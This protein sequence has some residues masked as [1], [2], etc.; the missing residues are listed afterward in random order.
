MKYLTDVEVAEQFGKSK[1]F[2]Q[3]MC[4][5][6][7]WPHMQVGKAYRF[8]AEHV[9]AIEAL[10]EQQVSSQTPAETWGRK[11]RSAS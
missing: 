3:R 11:R 9:S 6:K 7:Q 8:K 4:R 5:S 10:C 1:E 2:V